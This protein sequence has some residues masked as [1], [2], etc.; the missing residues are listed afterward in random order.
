[1]GWR[2]VKSATD[3]L[4]PICFTFRLP[5]PRPT[6]CV[7]CAAAVLNHPPLPVYLHYN[8]EIKTLALTPSPPKP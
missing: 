7:K 2:G 3:F 5:A 6:H 4:P 8:P 1:M